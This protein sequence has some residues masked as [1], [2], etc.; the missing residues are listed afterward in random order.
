[1]ILNKQKLKRL[2][3]FINESILIILAPTF[4]NKTLLL[5]IHNSKETQTF[6]ALSSNKFLFIAHPNQILLFF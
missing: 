4:Y 3:I 6:L 5:D 1:M 2:T